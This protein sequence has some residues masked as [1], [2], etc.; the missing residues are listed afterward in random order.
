MSD[1]ENRAWCSRCQQWLKRVAFASNKSMRSGLQAYCRECSARY[2]EARQ[3]AKGKVPRPRIEVP[4]GYKRCPDCGEVKPHTEWDKNTRQPSGLAPY[5]KPCRSA[6]NRES[7]FRRTYGLSEADLQAMLAAQHHLCVICLTKRAEHVDHDHET[8]RV[9]GILCFACNAALG[10][11]RDQP[12]ALRRAA[13]Y[14]EGIVWKPTLVAPG[15]YRLPS[16][17]PDPR[18]SSS[19]W[20]TIRLNCSPDAVCSR[21]G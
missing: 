18:R 4:S 20:R 6:R 9:R 5:C 2:Y 10:Q 15:V 1:L 3:R 7:Y 17:P 16:S 11:M 14:L 13:D 21:L 8:G 12:D 19:S